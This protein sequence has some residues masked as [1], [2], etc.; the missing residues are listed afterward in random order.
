MTH[1]NFSRLLLCKMQKSARDLV[2]LFNERESNSDEWI[3]GLANCLKSHKCDNWSCGHGHLCVG[4][5]T[6][7]CQFYCNATKYFL[8]M[9]ITPVVYEPHKTKSEWKCARRDCLMTIYLKRDTEMPLGDQNKRIN[10][11]A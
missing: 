9:H 11:T 3:E 4:D 7:F 8:L 10:G 1:N 6:T 5:W 2:I